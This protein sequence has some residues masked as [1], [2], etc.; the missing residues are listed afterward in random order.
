MQIQ[1]L[2]YEN[3]LAHRDDNGVLLEGLSDGELY[4]LW[5][6]CVCNGVMR[7]HN[8]TQKEK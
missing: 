4:A 7:S 8:Y 5:Q 3:L 1:N 6:H 2:N